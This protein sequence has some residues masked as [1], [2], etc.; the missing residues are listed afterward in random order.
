LSTVVRP[1]CSITIAVERSSPAHG[2]A[3]SDTPS[4]SIIAAAARPIT[5][6]TK[7]T[8]S[9]PTPSAR[10]ARATL[11]PLPPGVTTTCSQ[12]STSPGR[13]S[14]IEAVR[15]MVR[16]GPAINIALRHT[17]SGPSRGGS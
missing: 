3:R 7:P 8:S 5:P 15:S 4:R 9:A 14:A 17:I 13:S 11:R 2:T 6:G 1:P 12:R 10:A 16:F